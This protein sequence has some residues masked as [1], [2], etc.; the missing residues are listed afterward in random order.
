M[1]IAD[2]DRFGIGVTVSPDVVVHGETTDATVTWTVLNGAGAPQGSRNCIV[3]AAIDGVG[4]TVGGTATAS[5]YSYTVFTGLSRATGSPPA[6]RRR[7]RC[8]G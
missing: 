2:E 8:S 4:E 3:P 5:D 6:R 1:T 7:P